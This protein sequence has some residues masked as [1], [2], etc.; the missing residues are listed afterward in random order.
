MLVW[1][2]GLKAWRR[3]QDQPHDL[4]AFRFFRCTI[5]DPIIGARPVL[6]DIGLVLSPGTVRQASDG[7]LQPAPR[8][9]RENLP[10]LRRP[11][12]KLFEQT[13][14]IHCSITIHTL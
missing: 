12:F 14:E 3:L 1:L 10:R 6:V 5:T 7:D 4:A 8:A 2:I 9:V 11:D 13:K